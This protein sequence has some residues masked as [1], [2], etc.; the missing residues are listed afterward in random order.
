[1]CRDLRVYQSVDGLYADR[2]LAT[3]GSNIREQRQ[4]KGFRTA[5]AFAQKL[6]IPES[7]LSDWENDR[8]D[9]I[10][11]SNIMRIARHLDI[12]VEQLLAGAFDLPRHAGDQRSGSSEG[13]PDVPASVEEQR[14]EISRLRATVEA[15]AAALDKTEHVARNLIEIAAVRQ[16]GRR[17]EE[18]AAGRGRR[19]RKAG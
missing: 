4:K 17:V 19:G 12:G 10:K 13:D 11:L 8:Y 7:R 1:M 15:Y 3:L 9:D 16:Q 18:E 6:G 2:R 5:R 14:R